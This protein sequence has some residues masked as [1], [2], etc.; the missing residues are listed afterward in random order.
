[1]KNIVWLQ[2]SFIGDIV[3]TTAAIRLA[4]AQFPAARQ[5]LITTAVGA[6][7]LG[8][9]PE[10]ATVHVF[11]KRRASIW[12]ACR[13]LKRALAPLVTGGGV[14]L[15]PHRSFRS[16]LLARHLRGLGLRTITYVEADAAWLDDQRVSRVAPLHEAARIGLLLEPLGV[17]RAAI[18][19]ARPYLPA[20]PLGGDDWQAK[21]AA[22]PRPTIGV[23]PGS[24]WGTKRWTPEG[25]AELV[26]A[27]LKRTT[28]SIVMLGS[29]AEKPLIDAIKS[30][31]SSAEAARII[32]LGGATSLKDLAKVY[33]RLDLVVSNDSSPVHYAA[34]YDVPTVAI[35]GATTSAMGFGPLSSKSRVAE[36]AL[37]CRPCSD[38]GPMVCPLGHFK[39]MRELRAEI[40]AAKCLELL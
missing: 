30:K 22:A 18:V 31:V 25:F 19:A 8:G 36:I 39:C 40:V 26:D 10:L 7:V 28:G 17:P 34:A 16:A 32:D 2:T 11:D 1:M 23:A 5:H 20:A 33:P 37:D 35:F 21:L 15:R 6:E 4:A 9:L 29:N 24:I 38:H 3:L 13:Q 14:L 27:L 12:T